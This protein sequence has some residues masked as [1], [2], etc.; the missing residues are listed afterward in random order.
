MGIV[1]ITTKNSATQTPFAAAPISLKLVMPSGQ[2][3]K[4]LFYAD[5]TGTLR[6]SLYVS[7]T[8]PS[9]TYHIVATTSNGIQTGTGQK[10]FNVL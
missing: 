7:T 6:I 2:A 8:A 3:A 9:G 5:S 4:Y 1:T 10:T